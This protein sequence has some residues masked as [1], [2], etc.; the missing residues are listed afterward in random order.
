MERV[1]VGWL[2]LL[3]GG[4]CAD[5]GARVGDVGHIGDAA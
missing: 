4:K 3:L 5:D 2:M 1:R